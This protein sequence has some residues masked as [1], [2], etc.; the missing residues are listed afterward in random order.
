[1]SNEVFPTLPGIKWGTEKAPEFSTTIK[2]AVSGYEVRLSNRVYPKYQIKMAFE[3]LRNTAAANELAQIVGLFLRHRGAGDSFL[4]LDADDYAATNQ[5][6]GVGT[7]SQTVFQLTAAW[8]GLVQ[9][10]RNIQS[11]TFVGVNGVLQPN[12]GLGA[13]GVITFATA[14]AA[15][16]VLTWSG[17]YYYRCRF[18][19]DT[20]SPKQMLSK[21]WELGR[22]DLVGALG[23]QIG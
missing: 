23:S 8:G 5:V 6:F 1:M 9:P 22:C 11:L 14:P 16:S 17:T 21:L 20:L 7:G 13:G 4:L 18:A 2:S 3:F 19:D 10:A 15:G 12:H